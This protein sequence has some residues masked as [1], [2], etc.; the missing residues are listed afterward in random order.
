MNVQV[1]AFI[2]APDAGALDNISL[3]LR[4]MRVV[5]VQVQI[6]TKAVIALN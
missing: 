1:Y 6:T 2:E 3:A 4:I 5:G